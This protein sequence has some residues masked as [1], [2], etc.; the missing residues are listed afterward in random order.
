MIVACNV[1]YNTVKYISMG[2]RVVAAD[3]SKWN[4]LIFVLSYELIVRRLKFCHRIRNSR[5]F[6]HRIVQ[7]FSNGTIFYVLFITLLDTFNTRL[8]F[9][10]TLCF[11][12]SFE[13]SETNDDR[14]SS[15]TFHVF[16][17]E[18]LTKLRR[19]FIRYTH[20]RTYIYIVFYEVVRQVKF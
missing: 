10:H 7:Y 15:I 18:L 8:Y 2:M 3:S 14:I 20:T 5:R 19:Y 12:L 13:Q 16:A 1:D 6:R 4:A 17:S 9:T 11:S